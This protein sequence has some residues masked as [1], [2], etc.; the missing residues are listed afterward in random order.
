[1]PLPRTNRLYLI[2]RPSV[3][4]VLVLSSD[5]CLSMPLDAFVASDASK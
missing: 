2:R 3:N 5:S 4:S 1:M